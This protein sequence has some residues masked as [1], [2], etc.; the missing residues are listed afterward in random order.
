M[1]ATQGASRN[2]VGEALRE[3]LRGPGFSR[4]P[5]LLEQA[6]RWLVDQLSGSGGAPGALRGFLVFALVVGGVAAAVLVVRA[7]ARRGARG[8][9]SSAGD[10]KE[11]RV[12][13]LL[14]QAREAREAGELRRAL[15]LFLFALVVGLGERGDLRY[16][17]AWTNRELLRRG[18]PSERAAALLGPLVEELEEKE[19]GRAPIDEADVGRLDELCRRWLEGP[20][21][22]GPGPGAPGPGGPGPGGPG[23]NGP[24]PGGPEPRESGEGVVAA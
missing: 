6:L 23:P 11:R 20:E 7:L 3:V 13:D 4:E 16:R 19:F 5:S 8:V 12:R 22:G 24:G 9:P 1:L 15:R 18:A 17:E 14:V 21:P 10:G 2:E